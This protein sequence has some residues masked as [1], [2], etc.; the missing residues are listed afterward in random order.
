MP[1]AQP[2]LCGCSELP[3]QAEAVLSLVFENG[4]APFSIAASS[5]SGRMSQVRALHAV[6]AAHGA[7]AR[8]P[9][10]RGSRPAARQ[11]ASS[12]SSSRPA[13]SCA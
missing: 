13:L 8:M 2:R 1:L 11:R 7:G 4:T 6:T 5:T 3:A 12:L 10:G 9:T